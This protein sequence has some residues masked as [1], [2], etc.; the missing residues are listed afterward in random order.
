MLWFQDLEYP[1]GA[2]EIINV[3]INSLTITHSVNQRFCH[4]SYLREGFSGK[5][6]CL[7]RST[8]DTSEL[9]TF[10]HSLRSGYQHVNTFQTGSNSFW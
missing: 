7:N 1:T 6:I 2:S 5:Y 9:Q 10:A 8:G 3:E 4:A